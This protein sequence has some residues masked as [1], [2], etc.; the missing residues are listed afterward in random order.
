MKIRTLLLLSLF[1][2]VHSNGQ[3]DPQSE[4]NK[5]VYGIRTGTYLTSYSND[6]CYFLHLT[7]A[8]KNQE[9]SIGPSMG[10]LSYSFY[11]P[12]YDASKNKFRINS[13]DLTYRYYPNGR[14]N[15]FNLYFE[16]AAL[17]KWGRNAY[18]HT[19]IDYPTNGQYME[20][21]LTVTGFASEMLILQGFNINFLNHC[22]FGLAYGAGA[23]YETYHNK[24]DTASELNRRRHSFE[25]DAMI[26]A[27]L[28]FR[29]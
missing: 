15:V 16:V 23:K 5:Y 7:A 2:L 11:S 20:D 8:W 3:E 25:F 26:N 14:S 24:F 10:K 27:S 13:I 19:I 22:Y 6:L 1:P 17:Q 9:I 12:F 18:V 4:K 29:F 21:K 28:G